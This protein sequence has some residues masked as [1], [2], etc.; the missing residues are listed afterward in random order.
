MYFEKNFNCVC[1]AKELG[2][3]PQYISKVLKGHPNYKKEKIIRSEI[4]YKNY[5]ERKKT[6]RK[7]RTEILKGEED[8]ELE[9]LRHLQWQHSIEM[10]KRYLA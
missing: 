6:N 3:S 8:Y 2:I 9:Y 10:S 4:K 1:I 7:L 5:L